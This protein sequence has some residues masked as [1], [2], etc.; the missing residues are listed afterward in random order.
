M[1]FINKIEGEIVY[2]KNGSNISYVSLNTAIGIFSALLIETPEDVNYLKI[3]KKVNV[4]FNASS[5]CISKDPL[6]NISVSNVFPAEVKSIETSEVLSLIT[7]ENNNIQIKSMITQFSAQRLNLKIN[8]HIY[9]LVKATDV[10]L[11]V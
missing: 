2:I 3:G 5:V 6:K 7:L 11:E 1:S 10:M 4:V 9:F 8:D